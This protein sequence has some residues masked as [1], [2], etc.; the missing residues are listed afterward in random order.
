MAVLSAAC[1]LFSACDKDDD[2]N[3][4][5]EVSQTD[6]EFVQKASMANFAEISAAQIAVG[7][8]ANA[9]IKDFAQK[10]LS[11]HGTAGD[12]LKSIAGTVGLSTK[13]SLDAAHQ[14]LAD[15]LN[16][17]QGVLFDSAYINSQVR[18]HQ[19][20]IDIFQDEADNGQQKDLRNFAI[21]LLPHL[22]EHYQMSD[23]LSRSQY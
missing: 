17:L 18:D 2:N 11:E 9:G 13:D 3:N 14:V 1:L 19:M 4:S 10:M 12:Q 7:K 16:S 5:D 23:S 8:A 15:S 6:V 21:G 22:Q 20:A